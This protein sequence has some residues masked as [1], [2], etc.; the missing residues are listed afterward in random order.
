MKAPS[1]QPDSRKT[2]VLLH[3]RTEF[4][5]KY[6]EVIGELT[7]R[8]Y[9]VWTFDWR[10]QGLSSRE[11]DNRHKG[12]SN[13]FQDYL[14]DLQAFL[15]DVVADECASQRLL[16]AHSMGGHLALRHLL[17]GATRFTH[18]AICAPMTAIRFGGPGR[19]RMVKWVACLGRWLGKAT[20][21]AP[22]SGDCTAESYE[23]SF[24]KL[25]SSRKRYENYLAAV[26]RQPD[27][28]LGGV[29]YGWLNAALKSSRK[30][31]REAA[32]GHRH[33]PITLF[34]A[35]REQIVDNAATLKLAA[36]VDDSEV[37]TYPDAQHEIMMESD[38]IWQAFWADFDQRFGGQAGA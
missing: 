20:D 24:P 7:G 9:T 37:I 1:R 26:R 17:G 27:L 5:E 16:L 2:C 3:G 15:S 11:T 31:M 19:K 10:G 12:H 38:Q 22:G 14:D 8:G 25:T 4:I 36:L 35:G 32:G 23:A 28:E 29:T 21:Y 33:P 18:A 13:D 34:L 6:D 30:L